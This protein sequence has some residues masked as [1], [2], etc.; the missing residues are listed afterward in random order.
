MKKRKKE[1]ED[2]QEEEEEKA[3]MPTPQET[4]EER[5]ARKKRQKKETKKKLQQQQQKEDQD[6]ETNNNNNTDGTTEMT[7]SHVSNEKNQAALPGGGTTSLVAVDTPPQTCHDNTPP[8][9]LTN[10]RIQIRTSILPAGL[11]NVKQSVDRCMRESLL[12]QYSHTVGGIILAYD[13]VHILNLHSG[14]IVEELPHIHYNVSCNALVFTPH[15]GATV[16]GRVTETFH[17]HVALVVY[18]Y[19][20]ASISADQLRQYGFDYDVTREVWY[21]VSS[22]YVVE[23]TSSLRFVIDKV[24]EAGTLF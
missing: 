5:R 21:D 13:N 17:S 22:E 20:N 23:N 10:Q 12:M 14:R 3:A 19:F 24:H 11:G 7:P 1:E 6:V 16:K 2:N 18:N 4:K 8:P 15:Y 9:L